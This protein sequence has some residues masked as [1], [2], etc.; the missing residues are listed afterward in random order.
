MSNT[1]NKFTTIQ[2]TT[3]KKKTLFPI[4]FR[5][6]LRFIC[7]WNFSAYIAAFRLPIKYLFIFVFYSSLTSLLHF[8]CMFVVLCV[9]FFSFLLH[10]NTKIDANWTEFVWLNAN[11]ERWALLADWTNQPTERYVHTSMRQRG[12]F[13]FQ[14]TEFIAT[15]ANAECTKCR[16]E[17]QQQQ[18]QQQ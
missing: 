14:R 16:M 5:L 13:F 17:K 10:F 12:K 3:N 15:A 1:I 6:R 4:F 11:N 2:Q 18:Q 7:W 9:F 8:V